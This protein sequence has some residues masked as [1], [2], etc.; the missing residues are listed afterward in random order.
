MLADESEY[1]HSEQYHKDMEK[2][3]SWLENS[4]FYTQLPPKFSA[5]SDNNS[6]T[7]YFKI[8]QSLTKS[9]K[10]LVHDEHSTLFMNLMACFKL[11]LFRLYAT[12]YFYSIRFIATDA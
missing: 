6:T 4:N 5:L 7:Y 12:Q 8:S 3:Q 9:L 10:A 2:G 1:L 11:L